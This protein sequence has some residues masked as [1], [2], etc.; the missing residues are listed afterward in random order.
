LVICKIS[1]YKKAVISNVDNRKNELIEMSDKIWAFEET[2]FEEIL[3]AATLA[4]YAE[5][6]GFKVTRSVAG[7]PTAFTAEYG[8]GRPIIGIMG[9]FDALPGLSQNKVP[10]KSPLQI[11]VLPVFKRI[12][13]RILRSKANIWRKPSSQ[14]SRQAINR[15]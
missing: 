8:S 4:D 2:A 9:E 6:Q 12:M 10:E 1:A 13:E 11:L 7:I 5:S 3:S 15:R 14:T